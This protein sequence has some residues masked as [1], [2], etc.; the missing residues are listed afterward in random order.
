MAT[1]EMNSDQTFCGFQL[2]LV[3][4]PFSFS[5]SWERTGVGLSTVLSSYKN[6]YMRGETF[7]KGLPLQQHLC[8]QKDQHA[9]SHTSRCLTTVP[10]PRKLSAQ[11]GKQK[12][13]ERHE[14]SCCAGHLETQGMGKGTGSPDLD[15]HR[16]RRRHSKGY[17]HWPK[18]TSPKIAQR[19]DFVE[20]QNKT[21][22]FQAIELLSLLLKVVANIKLKLVFWNDKLNSLV[23]RPLKQNI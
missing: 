12:M 6:I 9:R 4:V 15:P 18:L 2:Q 14:K 11:P 13:E 5:K 19:N 16:A 3:R 17:G 1:S 23:L 20:T 21:P 10:V 7:I 22:C 8:K